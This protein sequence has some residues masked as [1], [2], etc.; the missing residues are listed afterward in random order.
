M[1]CLIL[2]RRKRSNGEWSIVVD[3]ESRLVECV[4]PFVLT[5]MC[6][7]VCVCVCVC[8]HLIPR[9]NGALSSKYIVRSGHLYLDGQYISNL[10]WAGASLNRRNTDL[11]DTI[12]SYTV[13]MCSDPDTGKTTPASINKY[14][15]QQ[16][17]GNIIW[18]CA[19][20]NHFPVDLMRLLYCGIVGEGSEQQLGFM[21][22]F[23]QD[24]DKAKAWCFLSLVY[25]SIPMYGTWFVLNVVFSTCYY[26]LSLT[27]HDRCCY[28][29]HMRQWNR[30]MS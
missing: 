27:Q 2:W 12:T 30:K 5:D 16:E 22:R 9:M 1:I 23:H 10:V 4:I 29:R 17:I 19:V 15:N 24:D 8:D 21:S 13:R 28:D 7:C 14:F 3:D 6:V 18:S 25:V 20:M 11:L 26:P